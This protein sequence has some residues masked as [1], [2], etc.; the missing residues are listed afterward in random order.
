MLKTKAKT[1]AEAS[2]GSTGSATPGSAAGIPA[3][4]HLDPADLK[5][6]KE[7]FQAAF[8]RHLQL[9]LGKDKY[10]ATAYDRYL[11][12]AYAVRDRLIERWIQTQ[13]TYYR[14]DVKRIYYLSMEFLMGRTLGNAILNLDM[15]EVVEQALYDL[16]LDMEEIRNMELEAGLGNGGLGRLA[17]C[18]L[19][20]MA[21]LQL[22]AYGYGIR[23]DY[24]MFHQTIK[25]G[26]QHENPDNWLRLTN[27]WEIPRPEYTVTVQFKGRVVTRKNAHG[28]VVFEWVD[29]EDVLAQP[30]DSPIPGYGNKTVNTLRLWSAKS[31]DEFGLHYFNSGDYLEASKDIA[32][33]ESISKVLYPNDSSM[34]GKELRLK[35]QYFLCASTLYDIIRRHKKYHKDCSRLAEKVSLQLNDTHPTIAIPE[36]MRIL[37]DLEG[38]SWEQAWEITTRVFAYT[39]HTLLPEALEKWSV[40]LLGRLLPRHLQIIFEINYRFLKQVSWKYPGDVERL[41]RMSLIEEGEN[42]AVRMAY[43]AIVGSHSVNGVA[44]LH[45][46]LLEALVVKDFYDL[47]PNKF[48]NKTNGITPR[49]WLKKANKGLSALISEKIGD[50]WVKD[51][52]LIKKLEPFADD[53]AFIKRWQQIKLEN[54]KRLAE[55]VGNSKDVEIN[56]N[57]MFDV[58]IK[59]IHEYKRQLLSVLHIIHLYNEVKAGKGASI[60]P[61]TFIFAGKAAP[62]YFVAKLVIKL[63]NAVADVVNADPDT[64]GILQV[65]F[66]EDYRVSLAEK[67]F[68]ASDLSE[69]ISTAGK[70]ASGT[71]NMK[72][73]INGA[74]TIGTLDGANIEIREE[75]GADNFFLFGLTAEQVMAK[76]ASGYNPLEYIDK[77][78][79]LMAV[80]ELFRTSYFC[81]EEPTLFNP[82]VDNLIFKDEYM[83]M[84]DFGEYVASQQKVSEL[85]RNQDEWTRKA[86]L[87]VARMGKFSSDRTILEY[88]RDIWNATPVPIELD[89][90]GRAASGKSD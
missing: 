70:E 67:I 28:N 41:K 31:A 9:S 75:V 3:P 51:F 13:H 30:F 86:I 18:F 79:R 84:A 12:V 5:K 46:E 23:Y 56:P 64:R 14:Q 60:V 71:G 42:R 25:N 44:Q 55:Y 8:F 39:N 32:L 24:G 36:M 20:S 74:L 33:A 45:T 10:S 40:D 83:L 1:S 37:V 26:F 6:A 76:R 43:L 90:D 11:A 19:D 38:F 2:N 4:S 65:N 81:P 80:M 35:Q 62:G 66:L 48:N 57:T 47:S 73:S 17:A 16:S 52:S 27:P 58:Q 7:L 68:P 54:K 15:D 89:T 34:N 53:P 78:P 50:G 63:I 72:F 85:Y 49:R 87:N 22:P 29:T 69:Q 61:R 88:N 82:L 21:T 77:D 59:R